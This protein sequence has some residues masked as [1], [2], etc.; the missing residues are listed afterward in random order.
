MQ[1]YSPFLRAWLP[2]LTDKPDPLACAP[3]PKANSKSVRSHETYSKLFDNEIPEFVDGFRLA[4]DDAKQMRTCWAA[5]E[6]VAKE[7]LQRF[8]HTKSRSS[9][10][11]DVNPLTDGAKPAE[12]NPAKDSRIGKYKDARD[13][14]DADTTSR[15][16]QV[17]PRSLH[18]Y[19]PDIVAQSLPRSWNHL[20]QRMHSCNRRIIRRE[21][22]ESGC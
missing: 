9:Q 21:R 12:K 19:D 2:H 16:R 10:L 1:V 3:P 17:N 4:P 14:V 5:G 22:R 13:K 6:D 7:M 11:G 18:R 8:L 20:C 15:L